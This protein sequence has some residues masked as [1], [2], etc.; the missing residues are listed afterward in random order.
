M[1]MFIITRFISSHLI[2]TIDRSYD[3]CHFTADSLC[4]LRFDSVDLN[5][6]FSSTSME[7]GCTSTF[8]KHNILLLYV[9]LFQFTPN[10]FA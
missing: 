6:G 1:C 9:Q 4:K 10:P 5:H 7:C 2:E 8:D 3:Y